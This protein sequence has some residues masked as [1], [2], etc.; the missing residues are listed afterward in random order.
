MASARDFDWIDGAPKSGTVVPNRIFVGGLSE[1]TKDED[2][3]KLFSKFGNVKSAKIIVDK[4]GISKRFGFVTF[5]TEDEA[6]KILN[7]VEFVNLK[8]LKLNIAPAVKK[9]ICSGRRS[10]DSVS[11][12]SMVWPAHSASTGF[13]RDSLYYPQTSWPLMWPHQFYLQQ[14]CH[15]Q[16]PMQAQSGFPQYVCSIA[17]TGYPFQAM[18][19][20]SGTDYSETSADNNE[21]TKNRTKTSSADYDRHHSAHAKQ[22]QA[23]TTS[24][25]RLG[26]SS[27]ETPPNVSHS[28][29]VHHMHHPVLAKTVNGVTVM[30]YPSYMM[31]SPTLVHVEDGATDSDSDVTE[32]GF[33]HSPFTSGT[34]TPPAT[35][36]VSL[37]CEFNAN[38]SIESLRKN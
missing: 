9:E 11:S 7:E 17:P 21:N 2:L 13:S 25:Q 8:D 36:L 4:G 19:T 22:N 15:L 27:L 5:E 38:T 10:V 20:V 16:S 30:A 28:T 34:L 23:R 6:Q 26:T 35:P 18:G 37:S 33:L 1:N 14:Q 32:L 3:T 29:P 31:C 24:P 12:T